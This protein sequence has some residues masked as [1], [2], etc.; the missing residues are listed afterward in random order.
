M[1]EQASWCERL[2]SPFYQAL[3]LRIADDVAGSGICWTVLEPRAADPERMKLPLR[4][5]AA[6]HRLVL[7][8]KLPALAPHYPGNPDLTWPLLLDALERNGG[9]I[10]A[11]LP[12]TVQTSEVKRSCA[13]L[14]GFLEVAR[15]TG[16]PLRLVEI[17]S[18]SGL[19]LRWDYYRYEANGRAWGRLDSPLVFRGMFAEEP[20]Q[21]EI[22]ARVAER[23]GCDLNPI[24]PLSEDGR[25]TLQSFLWPDQRDRFERLEKAI[26]VAR[27]VPVDIDRA[28][29]VPWLE[30]QLARP[31]PGV[32][33]VVFHSIVLLYLSPEART[34]MKAILNQ[35]G[36][37]ATPSAPVAWLS[38]EPGEGEDNVHLTIWPGGER[39]AIA[40]AGYHGGQVVLFEDSA[41]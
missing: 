22:D 3:F 28:D 18:S 29:A 17:G 23:R 14:P 40:N 37:K 13:L 24:D 31:R 11:R 27:R 39:R 16:L 19:N 34:R 9:Q 15:R 41:P 32:A 6:V 35:A 33:T 20:P 26:E 25:L 5:L 38:M 4:F 7:E 21:F 2:G 10:R 36:T 1:R 12:G 8:G 30:E